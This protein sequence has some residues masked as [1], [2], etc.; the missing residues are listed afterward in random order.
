MKK[1]LPAC[2]RGLIC[3][4]ALLCMHFNTFASH[5]VGCDLFYTWITGNQYKVTV[6]LYGN[7]GTASSA[8]Y[9][10][11]PTAT[12][13]VCIWDGDTYW[14][15]IQLS[16]NPPSAGVEITPVCPADSALTQCHVPSSTI[17]GITKFVYT[18]TVTLPHTSR[19]WRFVY[20]GD[21]GTASASGRAASITNLTAPGSSLMQLIDT[22]NNSGSGIYSHNTSPLLTVVP[23][24][25]FCL[26]NTDC[27]NPGA[28]DPDGDSLRFALVPPT[29]GSGGEGS[30]G[31]CA[32]GAALTYVAAPTSWPGQP[33]T[34]ATP[35]ESV[36]APP[37]F[38]FD[39]STGQICFY[40]TI[41]QRSVVVY[42]IEEYRNDT[43]VGTCQREMTF[44]VLTCTNTAPVSALSGTSGVIVDDSTHY[45]ICGNAGPW[46]VTYSA[47][48][49][50][51]SNL[52]TLTVTG[53]TSGMTYTVTANGT[54]HPTVTVCGNTTLMTPG[55][56]TFFLHM[57]D[58]NCPL[59]GD[60]T[61]AY[62]INIYPV[63]TLAYTVVTPATCFLGA[64]VD[65]TPGGT[66]K[67]W[68]IDISG[69]GLDTFKT[70]V[71]SVTV[72]DTLTPGTDT[73][74]V[75][76]DVSHQCGA[77]AQLIINPPPPIVPI[78]TFTNPSYCGANDGSITLSNLAPGSIDTVRFNYNGVPQTLF[79]QTVTAGG[80]IFFPNPPVSMVAGI[81]DNI[82]VTYG[83]CAS[84]PI[85][86]E[87]LVNPP[88]P[89]RALSSINPNRC[90]ACNGAITLYGLNPNQLDTIYYTYN[91]TPTS[92]SYYVGPDSM[93]LFTSLCDGATY[94]N[95][96]ARTDS[97]CQT[98]PLTGVTLTGPK[99]NDVFTDAIHYGCHGDTVLFTNDNLSDSDHVLTY[100]WYFGDGYTDTAQNP[101][102]IYNNGQV[103]TAF[104]VKL[105]AT[106]GVCVDSVF[107][108][109]KLLNYIAASY[110]FT[111]APY[112]C[113]LTPV[114]FTN[115]S[116]N[117]SPPD[118]AATTYTWN[119][120]NGNT[121][122]GSAPA[123]IYNNTGV[124]TVTLV[125][126]NFVPC[127]DTFTQTVVVDT[128]SNINMLATDTTVCR[129]KNI[130]FT[131][132]YAGE[133]ST[134][135]IWSISDGFTMNNVNP[136]LHGFDQAGQFIVTVTAL[137]RACPETTA[138]R[139]INVFSYPDIYLGAD[140]SICPGSNSIILNDNQNE[141]TAGASWVWNTG[142]TT[143]QITV[144]KP[145]Y[146]Y[147]VVTINGC[148]SSDTVC[149]QKDCYMDI[150]N[151]FTPNGDG[152]N[153][154]FY[155]RQL[156]TRGLTSFNMNIYNRWGQLVYQ[157]TSLDGRGWD[158]TFN[159]QP[160]PE[161][162]YVYIID[163]DFKDGQK[164]HHQGN[165]TLLR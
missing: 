89:I 105:Y 107:A 136:I 46:C 164:E 88:F 94:T 29:N 151:V 125:E 130:T 11:L 113:Q 57:Q 27:Y 44:V 49:S 68:T 83:F 32:V 124:Y 131:A 58:N 65:I 93:V 110:T 103:D 159:G 26:N 144:T 19:N 20:T 87:T 56:Y 62:S 104:A 133:G 122:V 17:P 148:S 71:D 84:N 47:A 160:Q 158:G 152:V 118:S 119:F 42:N 76:T 157:T 10:T 161:A 86:P 156:L 109:L 12:P 108:N 1:L 81:Y 53:L 126:T 138:T 72:V 117:L 99:L 15:T 63:P 61:Q 154:Y 23:T 142:E 33:L 60:N 141:T 4:V 114:D 146:Y 37:S 73:I 129:G 79:W 7:C 127:S 116:I 30:A 13:Y 123:N 165:V 90:G 66:G 143:S 82:I 55:L 150:P 8:A 98:L 137:Y 2:F 40:P 163:A 34:G 128:I 43:F 91:G 14:N 39:P 100:H 31:S 45:H 102:H 101:W 139:V 48:E 6:I 69:G 18:Q 140:T 78:A 16:I 162:V 41:T 145:G 77:W 115:T 121:S 35:L 67:P 147:A 75:F 106:N 64:I 52:I 111:P 9:S 54:N 85:G 21:N 70:Y 97:V 95:F 120:G 22:L 3:S 59:T 36:L 96:F 38:Y 24:P 80:Q 92:V 74:S 135:N 149:V 134:G 132:L 25:F 28:L 50:D 153:D 112:V 51:T 155:P 5:I